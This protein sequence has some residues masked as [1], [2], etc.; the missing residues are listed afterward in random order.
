MSIPAI[1]A[2]EARKRLD[3]GTAI[4]VDIREPAEHAREKI[5]GAQSMPLSSFDAAK[6]AGGKAVIFHCQ[7]GNR[8]RTNADK[9]CIVEA[10]E[11]FVLEGGITGWK[12]AGQ[13][14]NLDRSKPIELQRQVQI[15][16]GSL[17]V[18]GLLLAFFISPWFALLSAFVGCGLMFA[19]I[20]GWC[21]MAHLLAIMPW[22]RV[23]A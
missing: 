10:P 5:P 9:L 2:T 14:T 15:A 19:G 18:L 20:T 16:A 21:G 13:P 23:A 22:N 1:T 17:I 4:L 11:M 6:L 7:S 3:D 8:T 12:S